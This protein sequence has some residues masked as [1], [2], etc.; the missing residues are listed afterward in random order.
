MFVFFYDWESCLYRDKMFDFMG[1]INYYFLEE[2]KLC[3]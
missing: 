3:I 2:I 1:K